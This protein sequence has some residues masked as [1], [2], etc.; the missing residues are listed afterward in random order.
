MN[1]AERRQNEEQYPAGHAPDEIHE[2]GEG[3]D[4]HGH[5][6]RQADQAHVGCDAHAV[7][8]LARLEPVRILHGLEHGQHLDVVG[9]EDAYHLHDL[10]ERAHGWTGHVE[11][12]DLAGEILE[13]G[14]ADHREDGREHEEAVDDYVESQV[15]LLG[16]AACF[17]D[18]QHAGQPFEHECCDAHELGDAADVG[19]HE[20][21]V[22]GHLRVVAGIRVYRHVQSS[23]QHHYQTQEDRDVALD[24][25]P[26]EVFDV[27]VEANWN[28][29][30]QGRKDLPRV[31]AAIVGSVADEGICVLPN[32]NQLA[33]REAYLGGHD[34]P[35]AEFF[36]QWVLAPLV[37]FAYLREGVDRFLEHDGFDECAC[38]TLFEFRGFVIVQ[39]LVA[40]L[41]VGG[42]EP[43]ELNHKHLSLE[44]GL[45]D[46]GL[47]H[48]AQQQAHLAESE[49]QGQHSDAQEHL[50][51]HQ[52]FHRRKNSEKHLFY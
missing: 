1:V 37:Y 52:F 18:R 43:T 22:Q 10:H 25:Q 16:V 13:V 5:Q 49:R 40:R 45:G 28:E 2:E 46:Y 32:E 17:L 39:V 30:K 35:V 6:T 44:A 50:E 11:Q 38:L 48:H 27:F 9:H 29:D 12:H 24:G 34:T 14:L 8:V 31:V 19:P 20:L 42:V 4:Q 51:Q 33:D 47:H 15:E 3:R 26:T 41:W 21:I 7:L 23:L 36:A